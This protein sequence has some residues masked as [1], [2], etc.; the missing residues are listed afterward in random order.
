MLLSVCVCSHH[1]PFLFTLFVHILLLCSRN[2]GKKVSKAIPV[3]GRG[4]LYGCATS[5][6]THF[7]DNR[8]TDGGDVS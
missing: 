2:E 8:L 4:G 3:T 6:L 1:S 5:R 7:V